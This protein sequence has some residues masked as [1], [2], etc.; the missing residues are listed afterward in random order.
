MS[1]KILAYGL[2]ESLN[3]YDQDGS[4]LRHVWTEKPTITEVGSK[5]G[6]FPCQ[7][8]DKTL[9]VVDVWLGKEASMS[10]VSATWQI[11]PITEGVWDDQ[12]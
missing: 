5:F 2:F 9:F 12:R 3:A 6:G 4:Y 8:D 10:D 7:S 1:D 11:L